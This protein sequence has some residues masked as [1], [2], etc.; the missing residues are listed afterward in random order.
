M[1]SRRRAEPVARCS[2]RSTRDARLH[3]AG[4]VA[5]VVACRRELPHARV[6]V[7]LAEPAGRVAAHRGG[8]VQHGRLVHVA[9][10]EPSRRVGPVRAAFSSS[11]RLAHPV[12]R[13]RAEVE[14]AKA[15]AGRP[16]LVAA[17]VGAPPPS[18]GVEVADAAAEPHVGLAK[19]WS[20]SGE[21]LHRLVLPSPSGPTPGMARDVARI[22]ARRSGR[23]GVGVVAPGHPSQP[24]R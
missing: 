16:R 24:S 15:A 22:G 17:Q 10:D 12:V 8:E 23:L 13:R 14:A 11:S 6:E 20:T 1:A 3:A 4:S 18:R 21:R 2:T 5:G 19:P 7:R 9:G